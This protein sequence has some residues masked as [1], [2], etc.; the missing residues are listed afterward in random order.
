MLLSKI[1][2]FQVLPGEVLTKTKYRKQKQNSDKDLTPSHFPRENG[3]RKTGMFFGHANCRW[4]INSEAADAV[5]WCYIISSHYLWLMSL[6]HLLFPL[7]YINSCHKFCPLN[8]EKSWGHKVL[9]QCQILRLWVQTQCVCSHK[10]ACAHMYACVNTLAYV[11]VILGFHFLLPYAKESHLHCMEFARHRWVLQDIDA[12]CK[13]PHA[14]IFFYFFPVVG[15]Y[16]NRI[17]FPRNL[18][19]RRK[20]IR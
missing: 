12:F 19:W 2:A 14:S 6:C 10:A 9:D 13:Q 20:R 11:S 15:G 7:W 18:Q 4:W 1:S 3:H 5:S 17:P 8:L 16:Q